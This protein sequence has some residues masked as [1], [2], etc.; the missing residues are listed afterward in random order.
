MVI[1]AS[2]SHLL[3]KRRCAASTPATAFG[4]Y[5]IPTIDG[6]RMA[7]VPR[8]IRGLT[9][10]GDIEHVAIIEISKTRVRSSI[11]K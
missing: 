5:H 4:S 9:V 6:M 11:R 7:L 3:H 2:A 1:A 10:V 8:R